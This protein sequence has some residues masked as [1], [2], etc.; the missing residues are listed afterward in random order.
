MNRKK[1]REIAMEQLFS[2]I[3]SKNTLQE[4]IEIITE[5]LEIDKNEIDVTYIVQILSFLEKNKEVIDEKISSSLDNWKIER[6][7]KVNLAI[8]RLALVEMLYLDDVPGKVAINEAIE[9]TKKYSDEKSV[10]FVNGVLDKAYKALE[11]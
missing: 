5:E 10:S 8:L 4:Q 2:M 6:I 1:S 7:S 3:L 9:L 11:N